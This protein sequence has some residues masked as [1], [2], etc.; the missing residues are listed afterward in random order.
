ME[1]AG[2][3]VCMSSAAPSSLGGLLLEGTRKIIF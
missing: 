1:L 2:R 3:G